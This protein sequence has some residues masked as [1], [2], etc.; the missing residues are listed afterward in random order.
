MGESVSKLIWCFHW[1]LSAHF[2]VQ[3]AEGVGER[4]R[5]EKKQYLHNILLSPASTAAAR[6]LLKGAMHL[7]VGRMIQAD[8]ILIIS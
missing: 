3:E 4:T 8:F 7:A 6:S 5:E 2:N 1:L